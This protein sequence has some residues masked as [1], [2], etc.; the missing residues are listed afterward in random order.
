MKKAVLL[1]CASLL[2]A[3][4][5]VFSATTIPQT[6]TF[7]SSATDWTN[8]LTVNQFDTSLG[9]LVGIQITIDGDM[10]ALLTIVNTSS[11]KSSTG[12]ASG[13]VEFELTGPGSLTQILNLTPDDGIDY[14]L[15]TGNTLASSTPLT[16]SGS[17]SATWDTAG[18][19]AAF[20]GSGTVGLG[21]KATGATLLYNTGGSTFI[22]EDSTI[23]AGSTVTIAYTY[24][25]PE[26][27]TIGL[28]SIGA[29]TFLRKKNNK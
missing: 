9:T 20:T 12:N 28:L 14:L 15:G 4:A 18:I 26:P 22:S 19:L 17:V 23:D 16:K 2:I 25:V 11:K 3:T 8:A 29:L 21:L 13:E 10:S 24:N 27:A 5:P 1:T 6:F 7:G